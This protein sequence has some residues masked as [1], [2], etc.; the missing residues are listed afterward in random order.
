MIISLKTNFKNALPYI[1][2]DKAKL[3]KDVYEKL[4]NGE[5]VTVDSVPSDTEGYLNISETSKPTSSN[6]IA[7]IKA[8][9]DSVGTS[10]DS[11]ASKSE[12]LALV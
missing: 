7:E 10:Y 12:L 1:F 11:S 4:L 2:S 5:S 3:G 6:T 9:L 8:Y